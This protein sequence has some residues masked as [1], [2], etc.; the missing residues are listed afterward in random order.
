[1]IDLAEAQARTEANL[2][3]QAAFFQRFSE[4]MREW[5]ERNDRTIERLDSTIERLDR[6]FER[7]DDGVERQDRTIERLD[8]SVER[9][10]STIERLDL[11]LA[12]MRQ[13][14]ERLGRQ[15]GELANKMGT[16]V[17]D[18]VVPGI[19]EVFLR[20]FGLE[21]DLAIRVRRH[22][23]ADRGRSREF[24]AIAQAG[25]V[26]LVNETRSLLR[27]PDIDEFVALLRTEARDYLP[28]A[29]GR[30]LVG[31][32]ASFHVDASLVRAVERQ[33]LL[34]LGLARGL[35]E[36]LNSEGFRPREF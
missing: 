11:S 26:V 7:L 13:A 24:D 12:Q 20:L 25:D 21:P 27:P 4:E 16:L 8:R 22:H 23:P 29:R 5:R 10:D 18:I 2:D 34:V 15:L 17:E 1:M 6:N 3:R 35:L 28:E 31:A 36:V 33:G 30:R 14:E 9:Q 19:P 32:L